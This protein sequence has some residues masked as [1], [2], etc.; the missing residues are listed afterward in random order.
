MSR[1]EYTC[2]WANRVGKHGLHSK[3]AVKLVPHSYENEYGDERYIFGEV[4]NF[5][6]KSGWSNWNAHTPGVHE[7]ENYITFVST[8]EEEVQTWTD[9][10]TAALKLCEAALKFC[11]L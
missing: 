7:N 10:A 5:E 1:D 3:T 11:D 6:N 8:S 9:G 2:L 4:I